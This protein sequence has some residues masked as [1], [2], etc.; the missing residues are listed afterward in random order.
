M[1]HFEEGFLAFDFDEQWQIL[2]LDD[3]P[4]YRKHMVR[5]EG[6]KAVDFIGVLDGVELYFIEV[7]DFRQHR[8]ENK[9]RLAT[10]ELAVEV[11]QK[12]RDSLACIIGAQQASNDPEAWQP[13]VGLLCRQEQNVKVVLWLEDDPPPPYHHLRQKARASI[14]T[15]LFKQK[16]TWLTQRVLVCGSDKQG[17]PALTVANLPRS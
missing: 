5:L 16:L 11:G 2:K 7:K 10:G 12:V 9:T 17:L 13:Y 15:Q 4:F 14:S 1:P 6:S 3:H 8:I